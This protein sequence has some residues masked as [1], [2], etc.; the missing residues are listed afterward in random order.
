MDDVVDL[1]CANEWPFHAHPRL[2]P[3]DVA[4]MALLTSEV[5][6]YWI[7][8]EDVPVGLIRLLDLGDIERGSPLFDIRI[9]TSHR[10]RGLGAAAVRWLTDHLFGRFD[11]L[12]RIEA[13]TSVDNAAMRRVL[14]LC[15]Y[16]LEGQ[17]RDAWLSFDGSR[18]DAMI[19]GIVRTEWVD[20]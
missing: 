10:G 12:H 18:T 17:L 5:D 15:S 3:T 2:A 6:S 16:R 8:D 1:M 19:Y 11:V 9:A 7:L 14:E 13:T 20:P 4:N